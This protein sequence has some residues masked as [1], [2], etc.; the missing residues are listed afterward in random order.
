MLY[1]PPEGKPSSTLDNTASL[2]GQSRNSPAPE[3]GLPQTALQPRSSAAGSSQPLPAQ[4]R[5]VPG[6]A[7]SLSTAPSFPSLIPKTSTPTLQSHL[8]PNG[9]S[10]PPQYSHS[11]L[12]GQP[13]LTHHPSSQQP[14]QHR[15]SSGLAFPAG[16][17]PGGQGDLT[18]PP[19]G[20]TQAQLQALVAGGS[21]KDDHREEALIGAAAGATASD[22]TSIAKW[23][24]GQDPQGALFFFT[25][26][27]MQ[28]KPSSIL[29]D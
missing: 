27:P 8:F 7:P 12:T 22:S 4:P 28:V 11:V 15:R 24:Q 6:T 13:H 14:G 10:I 16:A 3:S 26:L 23:L 25:P 18:E 21:R 20:R 19:G 9:S 2:S 29:L 5:S 17:A 1:R